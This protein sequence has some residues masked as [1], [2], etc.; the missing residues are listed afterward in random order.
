[1]ATPVVNAAPVRIDPLDPARDKEAARVL[2]ACTGAG[3]VEAGWAIVAAA[4]AGS[5]RAIYSA[6][7][8]GELVAAYATRQAGLIVEVTHLAVAEGSRRRG[9]GRACLEDASR[10]AGKR[11]LVVE[12]DDDALGFY[13]A[14]GFKLVGRR[15]HPSG[16]VRYRLGWHAP[17]LKPTGAPA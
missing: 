12:T 7:V 2:A 6:M 11:P 16:T 17:R 15:P 1:M 5:A 14:C 4:R 10:R 9:Y 3:T 13:Q 8:D